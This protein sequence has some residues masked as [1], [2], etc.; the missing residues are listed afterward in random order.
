MEQGQHD[1]SANSQT[2]MSDDFVRNHAFTAFSQE[3]SLA[4]GTG[5]GL[6]IIRSIV[7][8]LGGKIDLRSQKGLGT[9]VKVWLSLPSA[10]DSEAGTGGKNIVRQIA[11]ETMDMSLCILKPPTHKDDEEKAFSEKSLTAL[12]DMPTVESSVK[13]LMDQWFSMKVFTAPNMNG[14]EKA[15]FFVYP[16]PP[17]IEY[18]L[19]QHGEHGGEGEIPVIILCQNAFQA[20]SL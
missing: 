17:S 19:N 8:S 12:R 7:D 11:Q 4:S 15:N 3:D 20:S 10:D 16:E 18:L 13:H 2:G 14:V 9:E 6:S 5:L 1:S